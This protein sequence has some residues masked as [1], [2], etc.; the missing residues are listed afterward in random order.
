MQG[1][2][3]DSGAVLAN[4]KEIG[5]CGPQAASANEM[6]EEIVVQAYSAVNR[7]MR[8]RHGLKDAF[9]FVKQNL[10]TTSSGGDWRGASAS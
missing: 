3:V 6:C 9:E 10:I 5:G 7:L 4:L 2:E 8:T 1:R